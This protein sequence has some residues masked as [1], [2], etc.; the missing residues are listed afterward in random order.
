M[1]YSRLTHMLD[2]ELQAK[3]DEIDRKL[4]ENYRVANQTRKYFL[5]TLIA[6]AVT[7]VLPFLGLIAVI[8]AFLSSYAS[9]G[10]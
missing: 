7:F 6:A 4:D 10:V 8:P 1:A 9:L 3:L 2:P 5:W